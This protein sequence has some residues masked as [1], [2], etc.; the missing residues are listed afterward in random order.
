VVAVIAN[1]DLGYNRIQVSTFWNVTPSTC[2]YRFL[3]SDKN[4]GG[5]QTTYDYFIRRSNKYQQL[6]VYAA[7]PF[8]NYNIL[9]L[10]SGSSIISC[11]G[12]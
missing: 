3:E 6:A 5:D 1:D 10:E 7:T 2:H 12:V 9:L 4:Y 11:I 8:S